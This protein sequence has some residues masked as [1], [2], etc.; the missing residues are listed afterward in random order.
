MCQHEENE[1]HLELCGWH[2]EEVDSDEFFQMQVDNAFVV[3]W[4]ADRPKC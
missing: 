1:Q 3:S 4:L 2:D